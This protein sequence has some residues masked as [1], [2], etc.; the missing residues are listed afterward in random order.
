MLHSILLVLQLLSFSI[1]GTLT[2][3]QDQA[4]IEGASIVLVESG[5]YAVSDATGRFE[6]TGVQPGTYTLTVEALGYQISQQ[7]ITVA[8]ENLILNL[9]LTPIER[10]SEEIVITAI[11]ANDKTP[12]TQYNLSQKEI[13]ARYYGHDIPTLINHAPSV[14]SFSEN[15]VGIGYSYFRLR[16]IDQTRINL[17]L[18]GIPINDPETQGYFFNNFADVAS[19][20]KSIQIQ[21]GIGTSTN[22]TASYGG[23]IN[24]VSTDLAQKPSFSFSSGYGSFVSRRLTGEFQTGLIK[25]KVAFYGKI[26]NVGTDGYR[27]HSASSINS[28]FVSGAYFGK[29]SLLKIN[30]FG[31]QSHSTLAYTATDRSIL[32]TNRTYNPMGSENKDMFRQTFHQIQYTYEFSKKLNVAS[33]AYFVKGD[34]YFDLYFPGYGYSYLNM[35]DYD[36]ATTATNIIGRYQLDQSY[37]GAMAYLNYS[38]QKLKL[39]VG[40]HGNTF[41]A[42]HFMRVKWAQQVPASIYPDHEA[43]FNTGYKNEVS[44]FVKAQYNL[45]EK[46]LLFGDAQVRTASFRYKAEDK[47]I[48]RDTFQVQNMSWLFFNPKLG[49]RYDLSAR[50]SFYISGGKTTREPTR[51]D[52]LIDDR[53]NFDVKQT[54]VKPE[55]VYNL[56]IGNEIRTS[57]LRLNTNI[58]FMEFRNEIA[59]TGALNAFGYPIRKNVP[60]SFRRGIELDW[61]WQ[62]NRFVALLHTSAFSYNRIKSYT[63][64]L[65]VYDSFGQDTYTTEP[66]TITNAVPVLTPSV[67][68]N[69]GIRLTPLSWIS[70]DVIGKYMSKMYLDNTNTEDLTTPAFFFADLR[71]TLKLNPILK[72]GDHTFS[73]QLNNFTNAKYYTSGTPNHYFIQNGGGSLSRYTHPAYFPAATTNFFATLTMKF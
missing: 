55:S 35:P 42:D 15:G 12:V 24:M 34:G 2:D 58:Y 36:P 37:Y 47:D 69:Q 30:S 10:V 60:E 70:L 28:Y 4:P 32:D 64:E 5:L 33:S 8:E 48:F 61:T 45:T 51:V 63:Q 65:P 40:V 59:A 23:A 71:L 66:L 14:N 9:P 43:Y 44:A 26:S 39:N 27:D 16:G 41:R 52:Y 54:D 6:L 49:A 67:I 62:I 20:L 50:T 31:G 7:K 1:Q 73:F 25:N 38:T 21:R 72:T 56:E 57:K 19:S 22:G 29:K 53:A 18:N 68:V 17:T 46:L 11:R 13:R 3:T